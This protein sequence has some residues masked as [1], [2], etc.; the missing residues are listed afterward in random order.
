MKSNTNCR[1][2]FVG[3]DDQHSASDDD[4]DDLAIDDYGQ[5]E[6]QN[7]VI[8]GGDGEENVVVSD[9]DDEYDEFDED[10]E[11]GFDNASEDTEN[12]DS[13]GNEV[14]GSAEGTSGSVSTS[15]TQTTST[16]KTATT[17]KSGDSSSEFD[18]QASDSDDEM[19]DDDDSED[20]AESTTSQV[21]G[22]D[23]EDE[24]IKAIIA[25]TKT[26]RSHPPDIVTEEFVVDISFHPQE[27]IL[28]VGTLG[29][30]VL[31]YKY[32]NEENTLLT[33]L[34]M[35]T[36]AIRD[37]EFNQDG[38]TLYS[39]SKDKSIV[40]SDVHTGKLK[41]FY[42]EAHTAPVYRMNVINENL[43][44]SGKCFVIHFN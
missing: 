40:L 14:V 31:V 2:R 5:D 20:D 11:A 23:D 18:S 8:L 36:K 34:E 19:G 25:N 4:D 21:E 1:R 16:K 12:E 42:D 26:T 33:T 41:R 10:D 35:H 13:S 28:A 15:A 24:V 30:D 39:A 32:S 17:A 3:R 37:I 22:M 7:I 38:S 43:F 9:S 27:D 6:L 44:A 29:G